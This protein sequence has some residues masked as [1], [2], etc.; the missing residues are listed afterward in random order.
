MAERIDHGLARAAANALRDQVV[1]GELRT[2]MRGLPAMLQTSG[3]A[4][5]CA[6]L[7]AKADNHNRNDAYWLTAKTLLDEAAK[8]AG[9]D[10][11]PDPGVTLDALSQATGL[12]YV[13][14]ETHAAMLALWLSRLTQ[15]KAIAQGENKK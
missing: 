13:L 2:R 15:A 11:H 7:L 9:I 12:Q 3:L 14:A 4:A 5:T 1:T 6:F 8:A 10:P